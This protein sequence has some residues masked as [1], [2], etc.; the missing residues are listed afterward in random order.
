[1]A[2]GDWDFFDMRLQL[3]PFGISSSL[4]PFPSPG[5]LRLPRWAGLWYRSRTVPPAR[6]HRALPR[7]SPG[8][9][10]RGREHPPTGAVSRIRS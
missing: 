5:I 2:G 4:L 9:A 6:F 7:L 1:M 3:E 8:P 10:S